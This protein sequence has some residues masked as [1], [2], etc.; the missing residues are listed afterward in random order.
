[1]TQ[2]ATILP[3]KQ[4][5]QRD[6]YWDA[7]RGVAIFA[8]IVIHACGS[9]LGTQPEVFGFSNFSSGLVIRQLMA[10]AVPLFLFIS[11]YWMRNVRIASAADYVDFL[12][13]RAAKILIP[14]LTWSCIYSVFSA[15]ASHTVPSLQAILTALATGSAAA[16]FY[17]ILLIMQFYMLLPILQFIMQRLRIGLAII[18]IVNLACL[19]V[20]YYLRIVRHSDIPFILL[21]GPCCNWIL[22]FCL[23]L[24]ADRIRLRVSTALLVVGVIASFLLALGESQYL[25]SLTGIIG[26]STSTI[27]LGSLLYSVSIILLGLS[28]NRS[29]A[30]SV[31]LWVLVGRYSFGI[32]FVHMLMLN[33]ADHGL[34][35]ITLLYALQPA[36]IVLLAL[37]T[38]VASYGIIAISRRLLPRELLKTVLAFG[39]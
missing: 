9:A 38:L 16:P 7:L 24:M 36:Y 10:F 39:T 5:Q 25:L 15:M 20:I 31:R 3:P 37:I 27:R 28:L 6:K 8:V 17:F 23:G 29:N 4:S 32:Y 1:M 12:R 19:L 33:I 18:I 34:R 21:A 2:S 13:K 26:F 14:Y 30:S 11:G 35:K 22:Y